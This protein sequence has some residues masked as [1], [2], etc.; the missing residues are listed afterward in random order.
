M[1]NEFVKFVSSLTAGSF[2][3]II[4]TIALTTVSVI[5]A[6]GTEMGYRLV[7]GCNILTVAAALFL[8]YK[9][10]KAQAKTGKGKKK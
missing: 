6:Y 9:T 7:I 3:R 8:E 1:N 10:F 2:L 4:M 5:T